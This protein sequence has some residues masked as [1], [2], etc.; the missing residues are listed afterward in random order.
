MRKNKS[1]ILILALVALLS[2]YFGPYLLSKKIIEA[3]KELEIKISEKEKADEEIS[4]LLNFNQ[5]YNFENNLKESLKRETEEI[6]KIKELINQENIEAEQKTNLQKELEE[7]E[8]I[9]D[10]LL[11]KINQLSTKEGSLEIIFNFL[12]K[13]QEP[14]SFISALEKLAK[15]NNLLKFEILALPQEEKR[16]SLYKKLGFKIEAEDQFPKLLKFI[17]QVETLPY[18]IEVESF[19]IEKKKD[20][21]LPNMILSI[22]VYAQ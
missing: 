3:K 1:L 11:N 9:L 5:K 2:L 19:N 7:K 21:E 13:A 15:E 18:L 12:A 17:A 10:N 6:E 14:V 8:K 4:S 16:G 20:K 22:K